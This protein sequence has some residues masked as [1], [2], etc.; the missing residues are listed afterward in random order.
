VARENPWRIEIERQLDRND[1]DSSLSF[2]ARSR[3]GICDIVIDHMVV[4]RDILRQ[5]RFLAVLLR[6]IVL[7]TV[8]EQAVLSNVVMLADLGG[9]VSWAG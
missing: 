5:M 1:V 3:P 7:L 9:I 6:F 2:R 4:P 8:F